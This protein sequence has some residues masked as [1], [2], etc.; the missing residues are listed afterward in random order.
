[1][2][3]SVPQIPVRNTRIRTSLPP[4]SGTGTSSSQRPGSRFDFTSAFI[5]F[6][7]RTTYPTAVNSPRA[8][9][10]RSPALP[11]CRPGR[12]GVAWI[13]VSSP[14]EV[15][16]DLTSRVVLLLLSALLVPLPLGSAAEEFPPSWVSSFGGGGPGYIHYQALTFDGGG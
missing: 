3:T 11:A 2:C 16:M 10:S 13:L 4:I 6:F 12:P 9:E 1:M 7:M 5:V 15:A 14:T 8:A